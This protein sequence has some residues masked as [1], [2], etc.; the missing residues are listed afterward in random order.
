MKKLITLTLAAVLLLSLAACGMSSK[1]SGGNTDKSSG[2]AQTDEKAPD[3]AKNT[4]ATTV[5]GYLN[6]FGFTEDELE[7]PFCTRV[8]AVSRDESG[9]INE[10]GVFAINPMP[11]RDMNAWLERILKDLEALSDDGTVKNSGKLTPGNDPWTVDFVTSKEKA[12]IDEK[13]Q[14]DGE[15]VYKGKTV[16]VK[17][18]IAPNDTDSAKPEYAL[19]TCKIGFEYR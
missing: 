11:E 5:A 12:W 4:D 3:S 10:V 13:M 1:D 9:K 19:P 8:D 16:G 6:S 2:S 14:L 17:I 18:K 7:C 15:Y